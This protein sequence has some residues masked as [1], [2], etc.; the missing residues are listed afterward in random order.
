MDRQSDFESRFPDLPAEA[1]EIALRTTKRPE[2]PS[3][4]KFLDFF[5][6]GDNLPQDFKQ[7][8]FD[9]IR[10]L[11]GKKIRVGSLCSGSEI[12]SK[13]LSRFLSNLGQRCGS[14]IAVD[15]VF[16]CESAS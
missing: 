11:D 10:F 4:D 9:M 2:G 6:D 12:H 7:E 15:L 3:L 8:L 14:T 5:L 16:A 1:L 13:L